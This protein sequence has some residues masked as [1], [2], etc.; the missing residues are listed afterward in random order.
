[1]ALFV[2]LGILM[3][4]WILVF[5]LH[6]FSRNQRYQSFQL[7]SGEIAHYAAEFGARQGYLLV[8]RAADFLNSTSPLTFPKKTTAPA[9]LSRFMEL[10]VDDT[11]LLVN[12]PV[13]AVMPIPIADSTVLAGMGNNLKLTVTFRLAGQQSLWP[14]SILPGLLE[15]PPE[16]YGRFVVDSLA[17]YR[18]VKRRTIAVFEQRTISIT[19]P[20]VGR[21]VLFAADLQGTLNPV[22][23]SLQPVPKVVIPLAFPGGFS[24]KPLVIMGGT[25]I[26]P[27]QRATIQGDPATFLDRQGW[28]CLSPSS[29]GDPRFWNFNLSP[30]T[31]DG[32]HFLLGEDRVYLYDIQAGTDMLGRT[33]SLPAGGSYEFWKTHRTY[34]FLTG[35]YQEAAAK[36]RAYFL[37]KSAMVCDKSS[38]LRLFGTSVLPSP[39]LV[40]G[41]AYRSF[42]LEQG[43]LPKGG[44]SLS[45]PFPFLGANDF[46]SGNWTRGI[47]IITAQVLRDACGAVFA[48]YQQIMSR[49]V[50]GVFNDGIAF[51]FDSSPPNQ[52]N[53]PVEPVFQTGVIPKLQKSLLYQA[54]VPDSLLLDGTT[55]ICRNGAK[56]YEGQLQQV[57]PNLGGIAIARCARKFPTT[58]DLIEFLKEVLR[59]DQSTTGCYLV[60]DSVN[61]TDE[62]NDLAIGGVI[63]VS[64]G[65]IRISSA[66]KPRTTPRI[67]DAAQNKISLVSLNGDIIINTSAPIEAALIAPNG[68]LDVAGPISLNI[69]GLVAVKKLSL[70]NMVNSND[71]KVTYDPALDWA[72][73]DSY[74]K[75]FRIMLEQV[76][77]M[78]DAKLN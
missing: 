66:V 7:T 68:M 48:G 69:I 77:Q 41:K 59:R 4:V 45:A 40:F 23:G 51:W 65:S 37:E 27:A 24:P 2:V 25:G 55:A 54:K 62:L 72:D 61:W 1:M 49:V 36:K 10:F 56:V 63:V 26:S 46:L 39:N 16:R 38:M 76:P 74:G 53:R 15:N 35:M 34:A 9:A 22:V 19:W 50:E 67:P 14:T 20:V 8:Q 21:F 17:E 52:P 44:G 3:A 18:G 70:T 32:E 78:F 64:K 12:S 60:E 42:I 58:T 5:S 47:D 73:A 28:I 31:T 75:S 71:K 57:L 13:S 6:Y 43:L 11:G 33:V 29:T 30:G